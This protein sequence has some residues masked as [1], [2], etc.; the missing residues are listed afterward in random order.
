[1]PGSSDYFAGSLV[2]YGNDIKTN[3][4]G[5]PQGVL[6]AHGAVSAQVAKAMAEGARERLGVDAAVAVTG[7]A[8]PDGGTPSKPVGLTYI[9]VADDR[10]DDVRRFIWDSDRTGNKRLSAAAAL[11]LLLD[12]V[13]ASA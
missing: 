10:G 3:V 5:V 4:A 12:R 13:V 1:I 6:E 2:T 8:G 11:E 7:V 9:A